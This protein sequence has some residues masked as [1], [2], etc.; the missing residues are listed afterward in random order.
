MDEDYINKSGDSSDKLGQH[1]N[2]SDLEIL[3]YM[4]L[5]EKLGKKLIALIK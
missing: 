2:V 4:E 3:N 5:V 1:L